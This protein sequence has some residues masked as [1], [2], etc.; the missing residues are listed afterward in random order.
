MKIK[1]L[2]IVLFISSGIVNAQTLDPYIANNYPSQV[3]TKLYNLVSKTS[4][5]SSKQIA[6]ADIFKSQDD[7]IAN[8]IKNNEPKRTIDSVNKIYMNSW[9]AVLSATDEFYYSTETAKENKELRYSYYLLSMA[10]NNKDLLNLNQPVVDYILS[11][12]D[13]L[14]IKEDLFYQQSPS[15][16]FNSYTLQNKY[17]NDVFSDEQY[18]KLIE[19]KAKEKALIRA[20]TDWEELNNLGLAAGLNADSTIIQFIDFYLSKDYIY[21]RFQNNSIAKRKALQNLYDTEADPVRKLYYARKYKNAGQ[22]NK[23]F[24]FSQFLFAIKNTDKLG[25]N[26]GQVKDLFGKANELEK[27]KEEAYRQDS[28]KPYDAKKYEC[29]NL[30]QI[31]TETQ[32]NQFLV[33][34]NRGRAKNL[35]LADWRELVQRNMTFGHD[36]DSTVGVLTNFYMQ[37]QSI[38]DH[39][40]DDKIKQSD[41]L[42]L[43]YQTTPSAIKALLKARR[44]PANNT[45]GQGYIW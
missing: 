37:R 39:Y 4:I 6:I 35:A 17:L 40:E 15:Q 16:Y 11:K 38:Y 13:S 28:S 3:V 20:K 19:I 41:M 12:I 27:L 36:K 31:L 2:T 1:F 5:N 30:K 10:I 26:E 8:M 33:E 34:K 23:P 14:K 22:N 24:E 32:Y 29:E 45:Q 42:K 18:K 9:R 44:S 7:S 21:G 43:L 25:L